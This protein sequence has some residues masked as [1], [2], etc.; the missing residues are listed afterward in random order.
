VCFFSGIGRE[1]GVAEK[2][3]ISGES[4]AQRVP[5]DWVKFGGENFLRQTD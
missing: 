3:E 5:F 4:V 1:S 2:A